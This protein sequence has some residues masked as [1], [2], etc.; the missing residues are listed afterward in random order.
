MV[1]G[2]ASTVDIVTRF[3][4]DT[5][6][7]DKGSAQASKS[8]KG[9]GSDVLGSVGG[10]AAV[11]GV[12]TVAA[13]AI[14]EMTFAAAKDR[15]E[16]AKLTAAITAAGAAT[17][18]YN[19][20]V[21]AAIV[22]GQARAFSDSQTRDALATLVTATGSVTTATTDLSTAQDIARL[23]NVDLATATD[24]VA[25]SHA[26]SDKALRSLIPGLE[27]G[28]TATDTLANAQKAAAG[29]ADL[30]ASSTEGQLSVASDSFSELG[31]TI[32]SVFLPILDA[33]LP[34]LVP[35]VKALGTLVTAVLPILIPLIKLLGAALKIVADVLVT[36]VGWVTGLVTWLGKA[37]DA[38]GKFLDSIN[39][40]KGISLP[41]LPFLSSAA[42]G[43][44][45][46]LFATAGPTTYAPAVSVN[47]YGGDPDAVVRA[48]AQWAQHNGGSI[49]FNRRIDRGG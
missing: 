30:F 39:P 43:P 4:A 41:S 16:Q 1:L 15:D 34:A 25:K 27:A 46:G 7:L 17:G 42:A 35:V 9:F 32:G 37:I 33:I 21:D 2:A 19:A 29:Q 5:S 47:V 49:A 38:V 26:G 6:D 24:A 8:V 31:E 44:S 14:G 18:D 12:A 11:A 20:Q 23:A 13:I 36:L 3:L 40:L 28:K 45:A 10:I 22:A 48:V